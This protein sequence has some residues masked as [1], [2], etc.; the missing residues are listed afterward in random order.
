[1]SLY[2]ASVPIFW[3]SSC[4]GR[5]SSWVRSRYVAALYRT[6][7]IVKP[8]MERTI[9]IFE[10]LIES[11]QESRFHRN[12]GQ[13]GYALKDQREPRWDQA[14]AALTKAIQI[15]DSKDDDGWR[16]YEYKRAICRIMRDPN[17]PRTSSAPELKATILADLREGARTE[18]TD[19]LREEP[20][21]TWLRLNALTENDITS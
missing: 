12:Y 1:M 16:F 15:R 5:R 7:Q 20:I 10:A 6:A 19:F 18:V 9:P 14:E 3:G 17:Y 21:S 13:L 11:D 2:I 8:L 4:M